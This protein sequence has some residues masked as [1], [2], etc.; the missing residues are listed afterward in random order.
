M[1]E[2]GQQAKLL[3]VRFSYS[4]TWYTLA[5]AIMMI[6][7]CHYLYDQNDLKVL[8]FWRF[9]NLLNFSII[10]SMLQSLFSIGP[11]IN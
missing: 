9:C 10:P 5:K 11:T 2:K 4:F 7:M 3:N 6:D 8:Q 1:F